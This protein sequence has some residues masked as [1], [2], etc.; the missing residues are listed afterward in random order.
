MKVFNSNGEVLDTGEDSFEFP[1]YYGAESDYYTSSQ[2]PRSL[3][4][5]KK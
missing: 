3:Q 5:P 1:S 4:A 2:T